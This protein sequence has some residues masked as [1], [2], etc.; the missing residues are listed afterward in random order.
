MAPSTPRPSG[1]ASAPSAARA[2]APLVGID[3][4]G[5]KLHFRVLD[6][7]SGEQRDAV[8]PSGDWTAFDPAEKAAVVAA[9]VAELTQVAPLA[10]GIGAHGSDSDD[11]CDELRAA[12]Q[13]AMP[14]V[15]VR[16]VN[17]AF[18]LPVAGS[19]RSAAGVVVGTGSIAVASAAD[20]SS[21]YAG[22]WGWLLGDHSSA[23]GIVRDAV[24]ALAARMDHGADVASDPLFAALCGAAGVRT[25]REIADLM[26]RGPAPM[27]AQW[28]PLV[29]D[30]AN[31]E[32]D[33]ANAAISKGA[34][35]LTELVAALI[36]RGGV[37]DEV[38]A[39]GGVITRQPLL[40][41]ALAARLD[42]A[43]GLEVKVF[44]G[45]AVEGAIALARALVD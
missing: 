42:A 12:M 7:R 18:L 9:H 43:L 35:S 17:D 32:S 5:T 2:G 27:W 30:A 6:P 36:D 20:G 19:A 21:L 45:D 16:V 11:E 25:L 10:I 15:R 33:A 40:E 23:W 38:V 34:D 1:V 4:G 28:A 26:E 29:F 8:L 31:A 41:R 44:R 14:G 22:G 37:V 13:A 39:G 24:V 3:A